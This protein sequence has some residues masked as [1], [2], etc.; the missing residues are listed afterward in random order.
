MREPAR[1]CEKIASGHFFVAVWGGEDVSAAVVVVG[2]E[3]GAEERLV[4]DVEADEDAVASVGGE[5]DPATAVGARS[6][7]FARNGIY[8]CPN[9]IHIIIIA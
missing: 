2:E 7:A 1:P 5:R 3:E 8:P 4:T 6:G 9:S